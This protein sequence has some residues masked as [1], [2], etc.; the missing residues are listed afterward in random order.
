M[1]NDISEDVLRAAICDAVLKTYAQERVLFD[2]RAHERS[3]MFHI[4]RRLAAITES[5]GN[6]RWSVDLE[7]NRWHSVGEMVKRLR[8]DPDADR[9]RVYPDLLVHDRTGSSR[10]HNL[11]VVEAKHAP[12]DEA[13]HFDMKK[14]A[15]FQKDLDYRFAVFLEFPRDA[16]PPLWS[17]LA[18]DRGLAEQCPPEPVR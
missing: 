14:L 10:E 11:L 1:T 15:V 7:Y 4:G 16:G 13:R 2:D 8:V 6:D 17:W 3:I 18:G 5:W 9:K 12:N